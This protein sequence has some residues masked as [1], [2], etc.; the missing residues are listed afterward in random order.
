[1]ARLIC[2]FIGPLLI[3]AIVAKLA[4]PGS[5]SKSCGKGSKFTFEDWRMWTKVTPKPV[6]SKGHGSSWVGV[7]V[8]D[9]AR[10][11]YL[12]VGA[13]YPECAKIVKPTYSDASGSKITKLY[14]MVKMPTGYDPENAD[15][16]YGVYAASGA[17]VY[18]E[19][20]LQGCISC[21]KEAVQT[22]Y[23]FSKE[24]VG[25]SKPKKSN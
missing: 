9:L 17:K 15:W 12:A 22:D 20:K 14:I 10:A 25:A 7:Y 23:L 5:A 8:G 2:I 19:G 4:V 13:P 1:M 21:H 18:R 16:W 3:T 6:V 24:V 11:T